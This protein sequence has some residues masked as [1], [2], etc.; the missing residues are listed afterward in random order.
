MTIE[1]SV[2]PQQVPALYARA[3]DSTRAFVAAI[4]DGQMHDPTPCSEWDIHQLLNHV[5]YG[6]IWVADILDGK[7]L[8]EV[9]D[10]YAG[11]LLAGGVLAAYDAA[12]QSAQAASRAPG[13][14]ERVCHISRGDTSGAA[15]LSSM[16]NDVLIHGW[17]IATATGQDPA[18][19][20]ELVEASYALYAPRRGS[21]AG[22]AFAEEV[23]VPDD[24]DMQTRL[25]AIVGRQA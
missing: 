23:G 9:G 25:L 16:F 17:D 11:D 22:R 6:T 10:R 1:Q 3:L 14:L 7:T 20:P 15:Y 13:V 2:D 19:D 18:L 12:S 4:E 21:L 5:V 8:E 24:A